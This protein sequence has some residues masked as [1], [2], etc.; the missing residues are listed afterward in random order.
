MFIA[1]KFQSNLRVIDHLS[2][3]I[4]ILNGVFSSHLHPTSEG[5]AGS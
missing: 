5:L 3:E 1:D 4:S 2:R